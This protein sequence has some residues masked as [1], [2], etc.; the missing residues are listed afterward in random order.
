MRKFEIQTVI[1]C[2][3]IFLIL[4]NSC[5]KE[6]IR[7]TK[8]SSAIT[9]AQVSY[10]TASVKAKLMDVGEDVVSYGNC[11]AITPNPTTSNFK[12]SNTGK[13]GKQVDFTSQLSGLS[14]GTKYYVR[15]YA[16]T[17]EKTIY[18]TEINFTTT[19]LKDIENNIYKTVTIGTQIWMA[20]NLKTKKYRNGDTIGTTNP[21]A[22][23]ISAEIS[24]KHQWAYEGSETNGATYGRLY[25]WYAATDA[26]NICPTGWHLPTEGEFEIMVIYL[27]GP[28]ITG[29]TTNAAGGKM[30]E[31]GTLHWN[32]PNADATNSSGFSAVGSGARNSTNFYDI[33]RQ[34]YYWTSTPTEFS[35][36]YNANAFDLTATSTYIQDQSWGKERGYSV[37]CIKD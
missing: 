18:S 36:D 4:N 5:E 16:I 6:P 31:T 17:T 2:L 28:N 37:R 10:N 11:W 22:K 25:T 30:K 9:A 3:L 26:R 29:S 14:S 12:T 19:E 32:N 23:D 1:I 27:G 20:E 33:G 7:I 34:A 13:P 21:A 8:F 35:E 15:A 24:P